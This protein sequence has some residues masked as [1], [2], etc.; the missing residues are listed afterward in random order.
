MSQS[1]FELEENS[2][3]SHSPP[4]DHQPGTVPPFRSSIDQAAANDTS[5][6]CILLSL[7]WLCNYLF[8]SLD[9]LFFR[10]FIRMFCKR[11]DGNPR[12]R[13]S[14]HREYG[15][16]HKERS[17]PFTLTVTDHSKQQLDIMN[18]HRAQMYPFSTS[19]RSH[20]FELN[21]RRLS[22]ESSSPNLVSFNFF[23]S[24]PFHTVESSQFNFE[25]KY[26]KHASHTFSHNIA[27]KV[28]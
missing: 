18:T 7:R 2:I 20:D 28:S 5:N 11:S 15:T 4:V 26:V 6:N 27:K 24:S 17:V 21:D 25:P 12:T 16:N 10:P 14:T 22:C 23:P 13:S 8:G 3:K 1:L 19:S 9:C